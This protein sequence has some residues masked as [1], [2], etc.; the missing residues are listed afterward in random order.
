MRYTPLLPLAALAIVAACS[1]DS[2]TEVSQNIS[3]S[4]EV[5]I[6]EGAA[7]PVRAPQRRPSLSQVD[8]SIGSTV[9]GSSTMPLT[10]TPSSCAATAMG[11]VTAVFRTSGKQD[12]TA[13]FDVYTR[14]T[15][16]NGVW[17]YSDPITITVP[18][19][20][21]AR[22]PRLCRKTR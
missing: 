17:S 7:V 14:A 1:S 5:V 19:A 12:G 2:P 6:T 13:T 10:L 16:Q 9:V 4:S 3:S 20:L 11:Q 18:H 22:T 8:G 15:Y 21:P